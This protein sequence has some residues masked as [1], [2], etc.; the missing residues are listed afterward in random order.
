MWNLWLTFWIRNIRCTERRPKGLSFKASV[1]ESAS[2]LLQ[3]WGGWGGVVGL[4]LAAPQ[5]LCHHRGSGP[6]AGYKVSPVHIFSPH[7]CLSSNYQLFLSISSWKKLHMY[8]VC[9][10]CS[11]FTFYLWMTVIRHVGLGNLQTNIW[12]TSIQGTSKDQH[13]LILL[14]LVIQLTFYLEDGLSGVI[15]CQKSHQKLQILHIKWNF[16]TGSTVK[17]IRWKR[18]HYAWM[19]SSGYVIYCSLHEYMQSDMLLLY[20][21]PLIH[22][23]IFHFKLIISILI[24]ISVSLMLFLLTVISGAN[25]R[26]ISN[27]PSLAIPHYSH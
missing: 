21:W 13:G 20:L 17:I 22:A 23:L 1:K 5:F 25:N 2:V 7:A 14:L 4:V 18:E 9:Y 6:R 11:T 16:V 12:K 24:Y 26:S 27:S 10:V 15:R 19:N 8:V 3:T